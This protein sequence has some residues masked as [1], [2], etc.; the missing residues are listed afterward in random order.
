MQKQPTSRRVPLG[1]MADELVERL[2]RLEEQMRHVVTA[3]EKLSSRDSEIDESLRQLS[4]RFTASL[5]A[6]ADSFHESLR[7]VTETF[8]SREDWAF[9]KSLLV[10]AFLAL[11]AYGWSTLIGTVHR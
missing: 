8:V 6:Q 11:I 2:A 1:A 3:V 7:E 4:D 10:A 9:W 5:A